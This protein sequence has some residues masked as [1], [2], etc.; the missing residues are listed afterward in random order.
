ML[1]SVPENCESWLMLKPSEL[2]AFYADQLRTQILPFWLKH[3]PDLECGGYFS[4]LDRD[5]SV[6]DPH[7]VD[8]LMQGRISWTFAWMFNEFEPNPEW[9]DFS[10]RGIDFVREHGFRDDGRIYYALTRDGKPLRE[11]WI[12]HAELSTLIGM[13]EVARATKDEALYREARAIFERAWK[14]LND[15]Y[16]SPVRLGPPLR[17]HGNS[18]IT[19]NV[20]QT[21]RAYRE[22]PSDRE[23]ILTCIDIMRRCH[24]R[25]DRRLLLEYT[26]WDG[27]DIDGTLGRR[28]NPGHMIEGGIFLIHEHW[29]HPDAEV[30]EFGLN[31]I[32]WGF[33]L[34]WDKE[35]GG[36]FNDTD[37]EGLPIWGH[38]G[39]L[40]DSKLWWQHA[41]GLYGL[42]L[43]YWE[44]RDPWFWDA[45]QSLHDYS[46]SHFADPEY[47]EWF[48]YLDRTGRAINHA[49]GSNR[50]CCYHIGRNFLW[51]SKLAARFSADQ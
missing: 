29:R 1:A 20:I 4:C 24:Y 21:L 5:G 9:L 34:G 11:P 33:E 38:D 47:G 10:R 39:L 22:E 28:I 13:S 7:K 6:Y 18:M 49:K 46:F 14:A 35:F 8:I 25:P 16:G 43:A 26:A 41:E 44:T 23:R 15:P 31:L 17:T 3:A 30:R 2:S 12:Y 42:L 37:A 36:I 27:A 50:K 45:Y 48:A 51:A 19:I 32:R 40:A